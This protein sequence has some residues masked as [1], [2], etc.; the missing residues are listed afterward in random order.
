G[1]HSGAHGHHGHGDHGDHVAQYRRLFWTMLVLATPTVLLSPM[2]AD[3]AGYRLPAVPGVTWVAPVLGTV[4]YLWGGWP[5][6]TGAVAVARPRGSEMLLFRGMAITVAS[7]A[8]WGARLDV[9]S[10]GLV[11]WWELALLVLIML[12]GHWPEMR[13]L[14]RASSALDSLA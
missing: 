5:F 12:L 6:L 2:F 1:E 13:S 3:I 14:A 10:H 11:F 9:L 8:S 7:L 4:V